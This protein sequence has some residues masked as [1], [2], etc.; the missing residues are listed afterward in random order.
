MSIERAEF[1]GDSP[2]RVEILDGGIVELL[3]PLVFR[4]REF[5]RIFY[6]PIGFRSDLASVPRLPVV[7]WL[8]ANR[9]FKSA[10]MHDAALNDMSREDAA[11]LFLECMEAEG[12][13]EP[14]RSAAYLAV[15]LN[16]QGYQP[17]PDDV[18]PIDD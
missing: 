1:V 7:Y 3:Y 6:A 14:L 18:P 11:T 5:D 13:S 4:S 17:A 9:I 2:L 8:A 15:K 16:D 10:V 12:I